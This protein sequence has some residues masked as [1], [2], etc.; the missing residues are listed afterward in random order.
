V[1]ITDLRGGRA[2]RGAGITALVVAA[3]RCNAGLRFL[4]G[5]LVM[6]MAFVLRDRPFDGWEDRVTLLLGLVVGAAGLGN[7]VGTGLAAVLKTKQ[8]ELTVITVLVADVVMVVVTAMTYSLPTA[9]GLG[10]TVG[11]CQALG[12]LSLDAL[13]QRDVPEAV[14]TSVFARSETLLQLAWVLGGFL[15]IAL[16]LS[17]TWLSLGIV[18]GLLLA[19]TVFV[20]R[21][22]VRLRRRPALF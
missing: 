19:W 7:T 20:V 12:K 3:L 18:A 6:Y 13:I 9:V 15:G 11:I 17:P 4:S 2:A 1:D 5:F 21:S 8:P 22:V 14:R 10:L 16:P